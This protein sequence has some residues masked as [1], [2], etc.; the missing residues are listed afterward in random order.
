MK[1]RLPI[2]LAIA[3]V[4]LTIGLPGLGLRSGLAHGQ[5]IPSPEEFFGFQM[6][7]DELVV[8]TQEKS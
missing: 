7:A 5:Q 1:T 4:A 8:T 2:R 3:L 6:G